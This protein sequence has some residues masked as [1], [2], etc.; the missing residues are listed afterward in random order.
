MASSN[1]ASNID[2]SQISRPI[3]SCCSSS[4]PENTSD[5][6]P[7]DPAS[8]SQP[9]QP[10][11]FE[12]RAAAFCGKIT[13]LFPLWVIIAAGLAMT[14][15]PMFLPI[16]P[17][18]TTGLAL[19]MLGMGLTMRLSDFGTVVST[20][21]QLLVLGMAMQFTIMPAL[22]FL[23]SR[24]AGLDPPLAIGMALLSACPGGT[25]SNVVAYIARGEMGLSILMTTCS[26]LAAVVATP[27]IIVALAGHLVPINGGALLTS[28]AQVVL[29]PVLCGVALNQLFPVTVARVAQFTPCLAT[30]LVAAVVGATLAASAGAV[31]GMGGRVLAA[32]VALH[33]SGFALGYFV[34]RGLGLSEKI[35]RT[36]SI[37]VGM[38]NSTLG[39]V[40]ATLHFADPLVAAPC[41][42]SA[43]AH[44]ILGSMLAGLWRASDDARDAAAAAAAK[45]PPPIPGSE[46]GSGAPAIA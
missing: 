39:A 44:A 23:F 30:L 3:I 4:S 38:Q 17:H 22:G 28:T 8:S 42:I 24:Y 29:A 25:A 21:P 11:T 32:V 14:F 15:P 16:T 12:S 27:A 1:S 46:P 5:A 7:H 37:E 13:S 34:S 41:A 18:L 10:S 26:T 31:V 40:L 43:C 6:P 36:N 9:Q 33:S 20:M 35:C 45:G 19:T 2:R